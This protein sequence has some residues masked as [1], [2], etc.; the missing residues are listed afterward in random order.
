MCP[1]SGRFATGSIGLGRVKVSGR[2]REPSPPAITTAFMPTPSVFVVGEC[3]TLRNL[4]SESAICPGRDGSY[5]GRHDA[6]TTATDGTNVSM[7]DDTT[8][9][10]SQQVV[11]ITGTITRVQ[12]P[13]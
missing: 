7:A 6:R 12:L 2:K 3:A 4:T 8:I 10:G 13:R 9:T 1:S 11:M 5:G